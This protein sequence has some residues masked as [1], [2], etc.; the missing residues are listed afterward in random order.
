MSRPKILLTGSAGQ[1]G[2]ELAKTL[3]AHAE[4]VGRDHATLD[5]ADPDALVAAV[6]GVRPQAIVNAAAYTAVD[7]A[8]NEPGRAHAINAVAPGILAEEARR[9]DALLIHF[10]TDYVFDGKATAP[11]AEDNTTGPLNVYGQS[12]LAGER[13]IAQGGAKSLILRTSWVYGLRGSNF[14]LTIKR[15]ATERN[16][17]KIV[18]DQF[19]VPNWS[20]ALAQATAELVALGVPTLGERAGVYHLSAAGSASWFEFARAIIGNKQ[21]P[22]VVPIA[23]S[24]YPTAARR[25]AYV[26]LGTSKLEATFGISL[27]HWREL[28]AE[29]LAS[30]S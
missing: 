27:R 6:R 2:F 21:H 8:E 28:L 17:L 22:R 18:A 12:K 13:A 30:A 19:G 25:P 20:R 3:A 11:Y 7:R 24:E 15:L 29:C 10:S 16:E 5:L 9:L 14:L 4:V 26:V 23:T 1:L